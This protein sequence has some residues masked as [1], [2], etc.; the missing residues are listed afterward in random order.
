MAA[1]DIPVLNDH[2][3]TGALSGRAISSVSPAELAAAGGAPA[4]PVPSPINRTITDP[5]A[6][7]NASAA[8][9][10]L[11]TFRAPQSAEQIAETKRKAAQSQIDSINHTYDDQLATARNR[12]QERVNMDNAVSVMSGLTGGTEAV[13]TRNNVLDANGKEQQA[14]N[15]Q[16]GLEL[17]KLYSDISTAADK[18]AHDQLTDATK[19]AE[20]VI[21]RRT[22][23]QTQT[24]ETVKQ[25]AM[26]GLVNFDSFKSSPQNAAVYQHA[27]DAYGGS[28]DALR[29]AFVLNRPKDQIIGTP[30]RIG[31]KYV[32]A[33]QNPLT[34]KVAYETLD[35]PV[36]LP[37]NYNNFQKMG[38]NLVAIPDN[39]D[40]DVSKL[41]TIAGAPSTQEALQQQLLRAQISGAGLNNQ[42]QVLDNQGK[43]LDNQKKLKDLS[44]PNSG[45]PP[46]QD[47]L[48]AGLYATRLKQADAIIGSKS[49]SITG[50]NSI[51][52]AGQTAAEGNTV[53]HGMAS[54]D[55]QSTRQAE[56]N[57]V[58]AVLRRESGAA[59]NQ[60]EFTNAEKQYFPRPGDTPEVLTQKQQNRQA[61]VDGL[62][63]AAGP[64]YTP[65]TSGGDLSSQVAAKGYDYAKM[66][67]DGY[68]DTEIKKAT[69]L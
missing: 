18:E 16:R 44:D 54:P 37:T 21:A 28:E 51:I 30:T 52:Y 14:I 8:D 10:F 43:A 24:M 19:S 47:Q 60:S 42:G 27:L 69:G 64:S 62:T 31:D 32:Q 61:A 23:N 67:A 50:M 6:D 22:A 25:M 40:G 3:T 5:N 33:Y 7:P 57:F 56:R 34:G 17:S 68:T 4:A 63:N 13:R 65:P 20:D 2:Y 45:K 48:T 11:N 66:K 58:N 1:A 49:A 59:I 39:W 29:A 53:T 26:G 55:V 15:N 46:T 9:T 41:K 12:G 35:M 38:D 36:D